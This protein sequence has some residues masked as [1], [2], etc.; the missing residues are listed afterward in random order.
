MVYLG[1]GGNAFLGGDND[2]PGGISV[3]IADATVTAD[4][5]AIVRDGRLVE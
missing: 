4:G 3:P 2:T 1:F 5:K